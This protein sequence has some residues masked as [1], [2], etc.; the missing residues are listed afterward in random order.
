MTSLKIFVMILSR[1]NKFLP[2]LIY[3]V[4]PVAAI[5]IGVINLSIIYL[6]KAV[7]KST[8][9]VEPILFYKI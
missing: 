2:F 3:I 8:T 1:R 9:R 7:V 6:I 5:K 4:H